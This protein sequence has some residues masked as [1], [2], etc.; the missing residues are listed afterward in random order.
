MLSFKQHLDEGK[1]DKAIFHIVFMAGGP[2]SGKSWVVKNL[3]LKIMNMALINSDIAFKV[4]MKKSLLS[5]AMPDD[6][7]YAKDIV[8][9]LSKKTTKKKLELAIAGRLGLVIDGT[10]KDLAK[11]KKM[12]SSF[13]ELGYESAMIFVDTDLST[14]LQRNIERGSEGDRTLDPK[15]VEKFWKEV[16][17]NKGVYSSL[18][19]EK[20]HLVDNSTGTEY[21]GFKKAYSKIKAW[22]S[23]LPSNKKAVKWIEEN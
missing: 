10:G 1:N 2:G 19:K 3:G 9:D 6:E 20:F 4:A 18:F 15:D 8:R 12:K 14:A 21:A 7:K 5:L 22:T 13:E 23:S 17:G 16:Q 11:I